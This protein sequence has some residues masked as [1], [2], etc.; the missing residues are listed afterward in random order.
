M[1]ASCCA[2]RR[3]VTS[4]ASSWPVAIRSWIRSALSEFLPY[5]HRHNIGIVLGGAYNSGILASDLGPD[6]YYDYRVAPPEILAKARR[7]RDVCHAAQR[8][9]QGSRIAVRNGA[10]GDDL[11]HRGQQLSRAHPRQCG[12]AAVRHTG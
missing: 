9:T 2:L 12:D 4:T 10:S 11:S 5:C 7:I 3:R 1:Q 6:S 8:A